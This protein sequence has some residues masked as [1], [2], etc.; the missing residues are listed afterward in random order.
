MCSTQPVKV[1]GSDDH[2]GHAPHM[3]VP[4]ESLVPLD[5]ALTFEAGAAIACGTGTAWGALER[6]GDVKGASI[7]IYGQ[8]PVGLS[9]TLLATACGARV[10]AV[11]PEP[12]RLARVREFGAAETIDPRELNAPQAIRDLTDGD[13]VPLALE[14]SGTIGAS[15]DV[16][17]SLGR[18]GRGCF[19]GVGGKFSWTC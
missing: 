15:N 4:V 11:D 12:E 16:L 7:A 13:G 14:T 9:A 10:I 1:L 19:V 18:W 5:D 17:D 3:R 2:G 8:G 6:L